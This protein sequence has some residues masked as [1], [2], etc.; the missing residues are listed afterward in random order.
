MGE[1]S[2]VETTCSRNGNMSQFHGTYR[3]ASSKLATDIKD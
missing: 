3:P 2:L 1:S